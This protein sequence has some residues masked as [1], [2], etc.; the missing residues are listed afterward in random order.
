MIYATRSVKGQAREDNRD[1]TGALF[2]GT[3][4][5]FVIVDGT[6]KPGSGQL[7]QGFVQGVMASYQYRVGQGAG[8]HTQDLALQLIRSVLADLHGPLFAEQCGSTSYLV[9]VI[10]NGLLTIAYEGDC[11][12]GWVNAEAGIDWLTAPHCLANWQRDR[13]HSE[14][15]RDPARNRITRS[16]KASNVPDPEIVTSAALPGQRLIFATDGF[17]AEMSEARQAEALRKPEI[18]IIDVDDDVTWI[19][20][21]L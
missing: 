8:D 19:D 16:Y 12:C 14:L 21:R 3:R 13:S 15:A 17:W 20:V 18:A 11:G 9:A 5:L 10:S 7:A 1:C 2:D 6:S 4:G